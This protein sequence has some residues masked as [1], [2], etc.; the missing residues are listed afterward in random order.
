MNLGHHFT[1]ILYLV[2]FLE[3]STAYLDNSVDKCLR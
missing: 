2:H 1:V 3:L